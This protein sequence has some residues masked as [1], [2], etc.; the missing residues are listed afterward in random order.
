MKKKMILPFTVLCAVPF[1]MVL[2]NSMLIPLLPAMR[3]EMNLTLF[4]V[5]LIITAFSVPAGIVIPIAGY[6]SDQFGRKVIIAPAL[7]TYGAGGLIAGTAALLLANPFIMIMV[8]RVIQG[9]GAGGTYQLAMALTGDIFQ[10]SERAKA[11]GILEAA[12]GLGKVVSPIT[13]AALGLVIWFAPFFAYGLLA[14]PIALAVWFLVKEP[15]QNQKQKIAKSQY[16]QELKNIFKEKGMSLAACFLAGAVVLFIL[17]G[18][19]SYI[20]DILEQQYQIRG[21]ASGLLIAIPV[22]SMAITA[23]LSGLILQK[24][25]GN[26]LKYVTLG[27][28][29]ILG[30]SM[31]V[32]AFVANIYVLFAALIIMGIGTGSVLPAIN[33]LITSA[34]ETSERG[35]ITCIYGSTRFFGVAMGPPAFGFVTEIGKLPLFLGASGLVLISIV[36]GFILINSKALLPPELLQES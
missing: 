29:T 23:Y 14:I 28:L 22:A 27:G 1:I 8:G 26:V 7:I 12:N 9:I 25:I 35:I 21:M 17:F 11:L 19:L 33:T 24:K 4:E 16:F 31:A 34:A 20:S 3:A 5:G 15:E 32:I 18:V 10:S 30:F 6:F 13:G 2:G 36:I